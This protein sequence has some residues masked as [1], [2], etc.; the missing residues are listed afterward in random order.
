MKN[1]FEF[2][3][4]DEFGEKTADEL[5]AEFMDEC[6]ATANSYVSIYGAY[7]EIMRKILPTSKD[8]LMWMA[9]NAEVDRG[10]VV[11]QSINQERLLRELGI[12]QVAYF[13]CL[14]DLKNHNAIRGHS[15]VFHINPRYIWKG[16]DFRRHKFMAKYPY[17]E[18]EIPQKNMDKNDLKTTEF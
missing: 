15:A 9:F 11:I 1:D 5:L 8:I 3:M 14:R 18:N 16:S 4:P 17:I 13:K 10:R 2:E 7:Y 12:S 6:P